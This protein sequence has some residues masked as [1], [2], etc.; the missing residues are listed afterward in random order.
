MKSN[1]P[2]YK[3]IAN[4]IKNK[5]QEGIYEPNEAIPAENQLA[6]DYSASRVTVR[7]AVD[8]LVELGLLERKHGSGTYVK[9]KYY[10][11]KL[12]ELKGFTEDI[13]R[14]GS[15]IRNEILK[16]EIIK[17]PIKV[18]TQLKIKENTDIYFVRRKRFA[19]N[20]VLIVEDTFLPITLFP[21]LT[22]E[23][24]LHSKYDFIENHKH[25]KI[26]ESYQVFLPI[27][28]D[29]DIREILN[30]RENIPILKLESTGSLVDGTCFEYSE[31]YF[32]SEEYSFTI[33]A[34]RNLK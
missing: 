17:A 5:I 11:H 3:Q 20:N 6:M 1:S 34:Q 27:L 24:M 25:Y 21:D 7:K 10:E 15:E 8:T 4:N 18:A 14:Y 26:K 23:T 32:K 22:Y 33:T 2:L 28:P 12:Y 29:S 31:I 16:Y 30:I 19:D 13:G 9:N